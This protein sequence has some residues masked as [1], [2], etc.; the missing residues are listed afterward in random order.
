MFKPF[1]NVE[2]YSVA[3]DWP[4]FYN[5][6]VTQFGRLEGYSEIIFQNWLICKC[7]TVGNDEIILKF[8]C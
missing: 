3:K 1:V 8:R 4:Q 2:I 7:V 6:T 5:N